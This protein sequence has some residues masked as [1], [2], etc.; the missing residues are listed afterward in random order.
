VSTSSA[1]GL[2]GMA[3]PCMPQ[4]R[5]QQGILG[6]GQLHCGS[7]GATWP[8]QGQYIR[9]MALYGL[10][11]TTNSSRGNR[12]ACICLCLSAEL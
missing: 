7:A 5:V 4:H 9:C 8:A 1:V 6:G 3:P 12:M 11:P 2:A 10:T